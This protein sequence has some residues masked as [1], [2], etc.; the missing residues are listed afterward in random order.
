MR[1]P[2]YERMTYKKEAEGG[3]KSHFLHMNFM[4]REKNVFLCGLPY[5]V[6]V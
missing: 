3:G 2:S 6:I 4:R 5:I 1:K